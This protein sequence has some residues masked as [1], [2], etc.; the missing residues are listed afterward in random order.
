MFQAEPLGGH[1]RHKHCPIGR[2][3]T[4][5]AH[6]LPPPP[7]F[8]AQFSAPFG[9]HGR[10]DPRRLQ[11]AARIVR[12]QSEWFNGQGYPD[13][14]KG[15]DIPLGARIL[16]VVDNYERG[17]QLGDLQQGAGRR[18]DPEVLASFTRYLD[19]L[20]A[21]S[22]GSEEVRLA[23]AQLRQGLVLARDLYT[24]RGL[25]LATAGKVMDAATLDK[26][27]N[28]DRVDPIHDWVYAR[29]ESVQELSTVSVLQ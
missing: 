21:A 1:F 29:G 10:A 19:A 14:L 22:E 26:I 25:L 9:R 17:S 27:R 18:F 16:A 4:L 28:F 5:G 3:Q 13:A 7:G 8:S 20:R 15:E 23:P 2:L 12:H 11:P 24:G 6:G